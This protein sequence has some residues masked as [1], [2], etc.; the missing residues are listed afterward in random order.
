MST[1]EERARVEAFLREWDP[2]GV[3]DLDE[4]V[5]L[6]EYDSYAPHVHRLLEDGC[7]PESL[8]MALEFVRT[9]AMGLGRY[10]AAD[11]AIATKMVDWWKHRR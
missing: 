10:P 1:A 2:I 9:G 11:L 8:A 7:T 6:S 4:P 5:T 3:I